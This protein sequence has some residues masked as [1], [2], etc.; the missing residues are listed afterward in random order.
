MASDLQ[1]DIE[2]LN[3]GIAFLIRHS[4]KLFKVSSPGIDHLLH[5]CCLTYEKIN[6]MLFFFFLLFLT[7]EKSKCNISF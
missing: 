3:N 1:G 2:K 6:K 7:I 5:Q 4:Q